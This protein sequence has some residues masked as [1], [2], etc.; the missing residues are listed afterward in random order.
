MVYYVHAR[1]AQLVERVIYTD[2]AGGSSPPPRT[3]RFACAYLS[4]R[5]EDAPVVQWIEQSSSK[6]LM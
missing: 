3:L 2:D 4:N 5:H 6:A 1:L